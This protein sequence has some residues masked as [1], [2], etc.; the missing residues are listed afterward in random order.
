ML[1]GIVQ[2][3]ACLCRLP[4][5]PVSVWPWARAAASSVPPSP[6][7]TAPSAPPPCLLSTHGVRCV[8][9]LALASPCE[10]CPFALALLKVA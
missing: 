3:G 10:P 9:A 8:R 6:P 5:R 1:S 2:A 7:F 4:T